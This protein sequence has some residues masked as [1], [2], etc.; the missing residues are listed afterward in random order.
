MNEKLVILFDPA[1]GSANL[2]DW[3]INDAVTREIQNSSDGR[4]RIVNLSVHQRPSKAHRRL[5][6]SAD[7]LVAG[8]SNLINMRYIPFRDDRWNM[9][10]VDF[11]AFKEVLLL[12]VGWNSYKNQ[13]NWLGRSLY[14]NVISSHFTH[15]VRDEHT[16][17]NL[18]NFGIGNAVNTSCPTMWDLTEAHL[19]KIP[20]KK[21]KSVVF[22]LTDYSKDKLRDTQTIEL[23]NETYEDVY[24]W[25]QGSGDQDYFSSLGVNVTRVLSPTVKAFDDLLGSDAQL[26]YVGT[27]LHAGIRALQKGRRTV[28]IAIDNRATEISADTQLPIVARDDFGQ[29]A[30]RLHAS[31]E[32]QITLPLGHIDL[33][34]SQL[35]A[36]LK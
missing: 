10:L 16:R 14:K 32:T 5:L 20:N 13:S 1:A 30:D 12:G 19:H 28:V 23:L 21:G 17:Q 11:F 34:R 22:T 2:G 29:L 3:I 9:S 6:A 36:L 31:W 26:D 7:L 35:R 4:V 15:S 24:F 8:G 18:K 25:P 27:R 33:L